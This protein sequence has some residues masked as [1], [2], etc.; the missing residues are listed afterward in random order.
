[1]ITILL[2][3][4]HPVVRSGIRNLFRDDPEV[5]VAGEA[6]TGAEVLQQT[7]KRHFDVVLLDVRLPDGDSIDL[8]PRLRSQAP[9]TQVV[10]FTNAEEEAERALA[11]GAMGF[12]TKDASAEHLKFAIKRVIAGDRVVTPRVERHLRCTPLQNE[13]ARASL[14][15]EYE[16]LSRRELEIMMMVIRGSAPKAIALELGISY[17]TVHTH[18]HRMMK[19]LG[20]GNV[21]GLMLFAVRNGLIDWT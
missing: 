4:D 6:Q 17:K 11:A 2:A 13:D 8:L 3:D 18:L 9:R 1:M 5:R 7:A 19:K 16:R 21:R 14:R 10:M 15:R 12:I 20:V